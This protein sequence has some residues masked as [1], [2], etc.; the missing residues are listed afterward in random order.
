MKKFFT[1]FV[2]A[3]M[4]ANLFAQDAERT[5]LGI[6]APAGTSGVQ[7]FG[8]FSKDA[9]DM[10]VSMTG[11]FV[12]YDVPAK[13]SDTFSFRETS[14]PN[15]ALCEN[16]DGT[17]TLLVITFGDVWT[18]DSWKGE[19]VK[20][21]EID[22][23]SDRYAWK[24]EYA[25][26]SKQDDGPITVT[27]TEADFVAGSPGSFTKDGVTVTASSIFSNG[28]LYGGGT[29]STTLGNF[30]KIEVVCNAAG[31]LGEGWSGDTE[32]HKVWA[33]T[34]APTVAYAGSIYFMGY[35]GGKIVFTIGSEEAAI[36]NTTVTK[37]VTAIKRIEKG[38]LVIEKNGKYY[39]AIGVEVK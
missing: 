6:K 13:A 12:N 5:I 2:A 1:L 33:G 7:V 24:T 25:M 31:N 4:S 37:K 35:V 21:I 15:S 30:T 17:W 14:N 8:T 10:E 29:F 34:P 23:S 11:W 9:L 3:L 19:P 38:R 28:T 27:I 36:K 16:I 20:M 26:P 32:E 22:Y 18:D 39:N